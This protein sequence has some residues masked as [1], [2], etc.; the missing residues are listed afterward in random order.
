MNP[1]D[2]FAVEEALLVRD[3]FPGSEITLI[4]LGPETCRDVLKTGLAMGAD[5]AIHLND[6][7]FDRLDNQGAAYLLAQAIRTLS[8]DLVLCGRQAVDDDMAGA[9]SALAMFLGIPFVSVVTQLKLSKPQGA[10]ESPLVAT[11]TRQ[12]E[13]GSE[14]IEAVLP[15]LLTCQKG[16]NVPRLPSLKGIMAAK[17]KEIIVLDAKAIGFDPQNPGAAFNRVRQV[18]LALPPLRKKGRILA[19]SSEETARELVRILREEEKV[20]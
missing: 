13:G 19:G 14:E 11:V 9:G 10:L 7:A 8:F 15:V 5:K 2:E 16:L 12:I 20:I 1:Y 18:D 6:T 4:T 3:K 17:K